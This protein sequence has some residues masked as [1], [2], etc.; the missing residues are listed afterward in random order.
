MRG[1]HPL[2]II[3][4][5]CVKVP[6]R[7]FSKNIINLF[8]RPPRPPFWCLRKLR[9]PLTFFYKLLQVGVGKTF[10]FAHLRRGDI[11]L[12]EIVNRNIL[13]CLSLVFRLRGVNGKGIRYAES[14]NS[15]SYV[16]FSVSHP[17]D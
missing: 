8:R 16:G 15:H 1:L 6:H 12:R 4:F 13:F 11:F 2:L 7:T 5:L 17:A 14:T 10:V 3:N 9:C